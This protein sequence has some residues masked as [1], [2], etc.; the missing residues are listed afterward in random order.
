MVG[1]HDSVP[2]STLGETTA[3]SLGDEEGVALSGYSGEYSGAASSVSTAYT[4]GGS[5]LGEVDAYAVGQYCC[6]DGTCFSLA[7]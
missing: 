6:Y 7:G 2:Y 4:D 1:E 5:W 3:W